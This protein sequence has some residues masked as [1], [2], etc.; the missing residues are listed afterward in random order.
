MKHE[1][2]SSFCVNKDAN[3]KLNS[4][5]SNGKPGETDT[6]EIGSRIETSKKTPSFAAESL[7]NFANLKQY[8]FDSNPS[9]ANLTKGNATNSLGFGCY[10]SS[11]RKREVLPFKTAYPQDHLIDKENQRAIVNLASEKTSG[12]SERWIAR[13]GEY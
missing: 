5:W 12:E 10:D 9:I 3:S 6:F 8:P 1:I 2:L 7:K 13:V 11:Q 4:L